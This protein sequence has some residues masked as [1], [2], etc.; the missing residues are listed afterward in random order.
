LRGM[1]FHRDE[2]AVHSRNTT[3]KSQR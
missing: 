3:P 1:L 2:S